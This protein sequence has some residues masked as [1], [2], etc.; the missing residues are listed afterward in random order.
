MHPTKE[1][2]RSSKNLSTQNNG[3][4]MQEYLPDEARDKSHYATKKRHTL[5]GIRSPST[6]KPRTVSV[7]CVSL[8]STLRYVSY[9]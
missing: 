4:S 5:Q 7:T 2:L 3:P 9:T 1:K 8:K 6:T